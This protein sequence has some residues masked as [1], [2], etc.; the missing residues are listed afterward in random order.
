MRQNLRSLRV[1]G[2]T[3]GCKRILKAFC[4]VELGFP[5]KP[6]FSGFLLIMSIHEEVQQGFAV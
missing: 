1:L 3:F 6:G 4:L 2:N 5:W